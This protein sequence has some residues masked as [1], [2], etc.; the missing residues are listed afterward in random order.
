M[1][2]TRSLKVTSLPSP[3]PPK[4]EKENQAEKIPIIKA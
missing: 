4:K 1:K 3:T 2:N